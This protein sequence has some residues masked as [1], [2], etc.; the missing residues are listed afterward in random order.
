VK[1]ID[2]LVYDNS[3]FIR[4]AKE[5]NLRKCPNGDVGAVFRKKVY[6][7]YDG[8]HIDIA[9]EYYDKDDCPIIK[10]F[11]KKQIKKIKSK[12]TIDWYLESNKYG[13]Y[14][15]FNGDKIYFNSVLEHL[16]KMGV[17][18]L[19]ADQSTRSADNGRDYDWFIRLN[20]DDSRNS[21]L[22]II[23]NAFD[24][25]ELSDGDSAEKVLQSKNDEI[26]D[27]KIKIQKFAKYVSE[28]ELKLE[29]EIN[30][31]SNLRNEL[32][33]IDDKDFSIEQLKQTFESKIDRIEELALEEMEKK[34]DYKE[35]VDILSNEL[36]LSEQ[37]NVIS[38]NLRSSKINLF[39]K[40]LKAIFPQ[41]L[42]DDESIPVILDYYINLNPLFHQ[43]RLMAFDES[44][45]KSKEI[46][47]SSWQSSSSHIS[48]G[49]DNTGRLYFKKI[50]N[51][52]QYDT[53]IQV[54]IKKTQTNDFSKL[55]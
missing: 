43:L 18:W 37:K 11:P 27:L 34:D 1:K 14:I 6:P 35:Q 31:S 49:R 50:K 33:I 45:F 15:V 4:D 36:A 20:T 55:N 23:N 8:N 38:P 53:K 3:L 22:D 28:L 30:T 24:S 21:I 5:R 39:H 10:N 41:F 32:S 51:N 44:N 13:H 40:I 47:S 48:T 25:F 9:K 7:I 52:K 17:S 42:F 12:K 54:R 16:D 2:L 29:L 26:D 46:H 19:R